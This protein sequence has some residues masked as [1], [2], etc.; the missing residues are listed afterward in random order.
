[1]NK[2]EE[3][4]TPDHNVWEWVV[5]P[6]RNQR[7]QD[8]GSGWG[9]E[10][11]NDYKW[12]QYSAPPVNIKMPSDT[13]NKPSDVQ[14]DFTDFFQ[15]ERTPQ[16]QSDKILVLNIPIYGKINIVKDRN[17]ISFA[18][19]VVFYWVYGTWSL[20]SLVLMPHYK[21]GNVGIIP[22]LWFE[23]MSALCILSFLKATFTNPGRIPI[24]AK[25]E[26]PPNQDSGRVSD[27]CS[28]CAQRR[29]K[30]SHHCSKCGQCVRRM[31][32]HCPWINN[33]VGEDNRFA[34]VQ[35]VM[36][37]ALLSMSALAFLFLNNYYWP[38]LE[39]YK[40]KSASGHRL[41]FLILAVIMSVLMTCFGGGLFLTQVCMV[42][43]DMTT[44]DFYEYE[45]ELKKSG[46]MP[47]EMRPEPK[48][49]LCHTFEDLCGRGPLICWF[50]PCRR[51]RAPYSTSMAV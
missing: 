24:S 46:K 2:K 14:I 10:G 1:M 44:I 37:A 7:V 12:N 17:G 18:S 31:D 3:V 38:Q 11:C 26:P 48:R 21:E 36:Y 35:L 15:A 19:F 32:H 45:A 13:D 29:P 16:E 5:D 4:L 43:Y 8:L 22:V 20:N 50:F 39:M 33:C 41:D 40:D 9:V 25:A 6:T 47:W 30:M 42:R 51:R 23:L 49:S 28:R 27:Y 34:F